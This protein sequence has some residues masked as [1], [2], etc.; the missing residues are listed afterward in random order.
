MENIKK[1]LIVEDYNLN[2][3]GL[4][5]VLENS[6]HIIYE[7]SDGLEGVAKAILENPDLIITDQNMPR[8]NGSTMIKKLKKYS[9]T[10]SIPIIGWG[11]FGE[12]DQENLSFLYDKTDA[13]KGSE[14]INTINRLLE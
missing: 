13:Y 3:K 5:A 9:A 11:D 4:R 2:K 12:Q 6:N 8:M 10:S 14:M 7:A 1:I